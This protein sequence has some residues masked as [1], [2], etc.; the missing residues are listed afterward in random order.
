M[1]KKLIWIAV[2]VVIVLI[3]IGVL[4]K[5][6][7]TSIKIGVISPLTGLIANGDNLGQGFANGVMLA[8]EDY[9]KATGNTNIEIIIEDDGYDSKKGLSAYQ[10]LMSINNVQ[11]LINLS[12]PTIDVIKA[13]VQSK[14]IP[15]IQLGA[16]TEITED[17]IFQIYPDQTAIGILGEIANK[18]GVKNM[19]VVMEQ[20]KAYEKFI[21]DF[22]KNFTGS[23]TI[24][25]VPAT[26]KDYRSTA[27]KV[28]ESN[29]DGIVVFASPKVGAQVL[30]RMNDI[31]YKAPKLYFD[32][33]LQFGMGDYKTSLGN[34][35][36]ILE[37]AK[38]LYSV[39][40][41]DKK[42][43][44]NYMTRFGNK[45]SMLSGYGYD[46]FMIAADTYDKDSKKWLENI[47]NY[48]G[49]GV[50]GKI[51]F[52]SMGLRPAEFTIAT[53]KNGELVVE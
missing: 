7:D 8:K 45:E 22:Q 15:V 46:A 10:K 39:V 20:V 38:G 34:N 31:G 52:D 6:N 28:K 18:D 41:F 44:E 51:N 9:E 35:S 26:E 2:V 23:T 50:T 47:Q 13:D 33:G 42:Y 29:P 19:V 3:I 14:G 48:N 37:G 21:S 43:T 53:V 1:N 49:E 40:V 4:N 24:I 30:S 27:L 12:S 36:A 25:R 17:N 11:G 5:P 16:E 32:I